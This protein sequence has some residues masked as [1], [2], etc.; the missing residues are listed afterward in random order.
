VRQHS[1]VGGC[2]PAGRRRGN[3]GRGKNKTIL[4]NLVGSTRAALSREAGRRCAFS[5]RYLRASRTAASE[6]PPSLRPLSCGRRRPRAS[7]VGG[8]ALGRCFW[9]RAEPPFLRP[10][11]CGRRRRSGSAFI[12]SERPPSLRPLSCG[13]RRPRAALVECWRSIITRRIGMGVTM[14]GGSGMGVARRIGR[15]GV[16]MRIGRT[17]VTMSGGIGVTCGIGGTGV[18]TGGIR[19]SVVGIRGSAVGFRGSAVGFRGSAVGF[20]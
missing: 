20:R 16:A 6:R 2:R 19:G 11:P 1:P 18:A 10:L 7:W 17:G 12:E 15:T 4:A 5:A 8:S 3:G 9:A 13:R 14:S